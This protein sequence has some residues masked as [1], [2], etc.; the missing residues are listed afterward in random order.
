MNPMITW[1]V[2]R[3]RAEE[4]GQAERRQAYTAFWRPFRRSR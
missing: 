4:L 3:G 1:Q 2:A